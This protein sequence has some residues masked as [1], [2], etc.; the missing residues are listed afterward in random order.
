MATV[1]PLW[2]YHILIWPMNTGA[3]GAYNFFSGIGGGCVL[4][5]MGAVWWRKHNC[6]VYRCWR[7]QWHPD[8]ETG[9]PICR[10]HHPEHP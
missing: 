3:N 8:P 9:H 7:L 2:L 6:H 1:L 10:H 5:P 4:L